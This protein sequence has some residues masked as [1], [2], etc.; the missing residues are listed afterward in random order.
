MPLNDSKDCITWYKCA[1]GIL[2][3]CNMS[4]CSCKKRCAHGYHHRL[5]HFKV[6]PP[7]AIA[8][9]T[10]LLT[11]LWHLIA[12]V[13]CQMAAA[14]GGGRNGGGDN[15]A[16]T[17]GG[18]AGGLTQV[19]ISNCHIRIMQCA[20]LRELEWLITA[21]PCALLSYNTVCLENNVTG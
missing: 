2:C 14:G 1:L 5:S 10:P 15:I 17:S 4:Q 3:C 11:D 20:T 6:C 21:D 8:D 19:H 16:S 9:S 18:T 13:L 12:I 7:H